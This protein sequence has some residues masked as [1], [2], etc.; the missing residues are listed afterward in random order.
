[1]GSLSEDR[2]IWL[3]VL[4]FTLLRVLLAAVAPLA[5]EEAYYWIWSRNL[6]WS[7]FDH[8]PLASDSIRLTTA[9]FGQTAFGIKAA[10]VLWSLVLN[11]IWVRLVL[12]MFSDRRLAF[13]SLAALNLTMVYEVYGFVISPDAPLIAAWAGVVWAVWRASQ[14]GASRWWYVAG[15]FLGMG[16]LAKYP[17][18]LLGPVVLLYLLVS[19]RQR[20]WL[21]TPHPYLACL[22]ALVVFTPVLV[23]NAQHDWASFAFQT[24][25][26]IAGMGQWRPKYLAE[27]V[28]SQLLMATPYLLVV[29][30]CSLLRGW[31]D[32]SQ[33]AT[34]DRTLL[35][36]IAGA[37]PL[38]FF[39]S[40]SMRSLVKMNWPAPAYWPLIILGVRWILRR[41]DLAWRFVAGLGSSAALF[42]LAA[43]GMDIPNLPLGE[44]N[45][46]SGWKEGAARIEQI[47]ASLRGRGEDSFVF[48]PNYKIS[49]LLEFYLPGQ[50]RTYAQDT[51]G[52]PALQFDYMPVGRDLK[53]E[54]GI[55]VVDD[56]RESNI[57]RS[58]IEPYFNSIELAETLEITGLGRH[59]RRIDIYLCKN[60][61]GH[62]SPG[63][64]RASP[65]HGACGTPGA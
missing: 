35:L 5:P 45:T 2:S 13:W 27:L 42:V 29:A 25:R 30:I 15:A 22:V 12:D 57:P 65:C 59:T 6:A 1:M 18:V 33:V 31:R 44:A 60:Y 16:C 63:R 19:P 28:A 23:W 20:R 48:S 24:S 7:Y 34:D 17:A 32:R 11:L 41:R 3:L 36:L 46:W 8:P 9:I 53:G 37:V 62:P 49:S 58:L 43:V 39:A 47:Q 14:T 50:P 64:I 21:A 38:V 40:A 52:Q 51:F 61:R 26:R 4:G 10:A 54:T 55:M 56:R